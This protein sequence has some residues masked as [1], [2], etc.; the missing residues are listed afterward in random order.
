[1]LERLCSAASLA[2]LLRNRRRSQ[3]FARS[4]SASLPTRDLCTLGLIAHSKGCRYLPSALPVHLIDPIETVLRKPRII[5]LSGL[6]LRPKLFILRG[7]MYRVR[8][9]SPNS[10]TSFLRQK[11]IVKATISRRNRTVR[12]LRSSPLFIRYRKRYKSRRQAKSWQVPKKRNGRKHS[13]K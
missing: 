13:W 10:L 1:M 11:R 6:S 9:P 3:S 7:I 2:H 8:P 4:L 5:F 12:E